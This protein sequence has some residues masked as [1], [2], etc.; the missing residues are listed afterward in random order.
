MTFLKSVSATDIDDSFNPF[1]MKERWI[2]FFRTG[3]SKFILDTD[4]A[5]KNRYSESLF[6]F[7]TDELQTF[8]DVQLVRCWLVLTMIHDNK[9][10]KLK[11]K[12]F[13]LLTNNIW[14]GKFQ[15]R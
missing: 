10:N 1:K 11:D 2:K 13:M 14:Y 3:L 7:I 5:L 4:R 9:N 6:E 12:V 8:N 15:L